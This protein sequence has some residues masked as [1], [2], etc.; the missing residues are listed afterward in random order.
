[1]Y[2]VLLALMP[3]A[4]GGNISFGTWY[5]FGFSGTGVPA[6]GCQPADL[7]GPFCTPSFGTP[8]T[9][10]DAPNWTFIAPA[11]GAFIT[12]TDAFTTVERFEVFDGLTSLGLTSLP[13]DQG[14]C[15]DDPVVC[16]IDPN[17]STGTFAVAAGPRS[18]SI[19]PTVSPDGLG[20]AYFMVT[21]GAETTVPEPAS[22]IP[23]L[24]GLGT[25]AIR[26]LK[27]SL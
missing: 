21:A 18:F 25:V 5:Q 17:A 27:G 15:G 16:L 2:S 20:S 6:T 26:R 14:D 8:T 24:L 19:V 1:L 13:N 12:V 11:G 4:H 10:A 23:A 7:I 22:W 3:C 9:F